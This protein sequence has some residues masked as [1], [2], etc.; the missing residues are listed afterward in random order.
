MSDL[1]GYGKDD[2]MGTEAA[3]PRNFGQTGSNRRY[4]KA[5]NG[6]AINDTFTLFHATATPWTLGNE[7]PPPRSSP[8][9]R[10]GCNTLGTG[11]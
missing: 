11:T 1:K 6:A 9:A 7:F 5:P 3:G 4:R 8:P 2:P 10:L